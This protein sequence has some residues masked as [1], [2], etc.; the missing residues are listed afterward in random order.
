MK[1]FLRKWR[2]QGVMVFVYLDDILVLANTKSLALSSIQLVVKDLEDSSM[3]I[4]HPKSQ[5][6]NVQLLTHLGFSLDFKQGFLGVPPQ[7]L[8]TM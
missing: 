7:K 3:V 8:K 5:L 6:V 4:N 2:M 1:V